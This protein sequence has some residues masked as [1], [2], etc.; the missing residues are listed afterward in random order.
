MRIAG[1]EVGN[2]QPVAGLGPARQHL[3]ESS[4]FRRFEPRD[5]E[6]WQKRRAYFRELEAR[7][8]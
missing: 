4:K 8:H 3:V 2:A 5:Q 1:A 6:E 7:F